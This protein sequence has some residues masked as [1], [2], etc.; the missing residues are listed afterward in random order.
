MRALVV[1]ESMFGNT[2]DVAEAVAHGLNGAGVAT[3]VVEVSAAPHHLDAT[4]DLLVVG[5]P[6]HAFG[7]SRDSTR[8]DAA[9]K[10]HGPIISRG[11]GLRDWFGELARGDVPAGAAFST[12]VRKPKVPG[13]AAKALAKRLTQQ[14]CRRAR[15]PEDFWVEGLEG[16]LLAG[17][18]ERARQWGGELAAAAST[19]AGP[20]N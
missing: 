19:T 12:R 18:L 17:E 16:P 11:I 2:R 13:S 15:P 10:G 4:L 3:D 9:T 5:A 14:G 1:Y 8:A 7:L 6:T 20:A